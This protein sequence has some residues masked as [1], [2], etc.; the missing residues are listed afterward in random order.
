MES[1]NDWIA[2]VGSVAPWVAIAAAVALVA[3]FFIPYASATESFRATLESA[4]AAPDL[5]VQS[6]GLTP[7]EAA[8]VSLLG[9]ARAMAQLGGEQFNGASVYMGIY[10]ALGAVSVLTLLLALFRKPVGAIVFALAAFGLNS[11]IASDFEYRSVIPGTNYDWGP[12]RWVYMGAAIVVI[13]AAVFVFIAKRRE[14]AARRA[15]TAH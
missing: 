15:E 9:Y 8:D 10:I 13:V 14:K 7:A 1:K 3:A 6:T 5:F 2:T 12:A 4:A 11:F